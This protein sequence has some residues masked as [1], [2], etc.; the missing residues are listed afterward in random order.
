MPRMKLLT[1]MLQQTC[2]YWAPS[3][4][5][6]NGRTTFIDPVQLR[7]RWEEVREAYQAKDG[8]TAVAS[9]KVFVESDVLEQGILWQGT[10]ATVVDAVNPLRNPRAHVIRSFSKLPTLYPD[11]YLRTALL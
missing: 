11:E 7:C 10:L 2:V 5:D 6:R 4:P 9:S 1:T 3:T 8:T